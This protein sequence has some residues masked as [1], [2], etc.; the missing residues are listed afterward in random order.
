MKTRIV[1]ALA[2][3]LAGAAC[4]SI[5]EF[6]WADSYQAAV[7]PEGEYLIAAGDVL[8]V[9]VYGQDNMSGR[10]K[11]RSDGRIS[12]PFVND[13]QVTGMTPA[14][15]GRLLQT[16]YKA[17]V[18]GPVVT[19]SVEE[20]RAIQVSVIGEVAKPGIYRI[21][22]GQGVLH[23]VAQ[24]G[25]LTQ[26]A[27]RDRIFVVRRAPTQ[28]DPLHQVRIRFKWQSLV[29]AE[30]SATSFQLADGDVLVAE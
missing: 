29:H 15:L 17:Y 12:L 27:S 2:A 5:G 25:G 14:A 6:V 9:R 30:G 11:V 7:R 22:P 8:N 4:T 24:A 1:V 26:F 21:E 19:V 20:Q 28:V 3:A 16:Q 10:V 13:Q 18:N 23:G